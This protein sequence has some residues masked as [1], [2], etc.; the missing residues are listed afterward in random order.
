[1][2]RQLR[3]ILARV[4]MVSTVCLSSAPIDKL[5]AAEPPLAQQISEPVSPTDDA[6]HTALIPQRLLWP[7]IVVIVVIAIFITA[8]V[9]GPII[10]ANTRDEPPDS[11]S[12]K[13][14]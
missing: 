1:M 14:Q 6:S 8:A 7:G 9:A 4:L 10:R 3:H 2:T 12:S 13:G 5:R 11:D